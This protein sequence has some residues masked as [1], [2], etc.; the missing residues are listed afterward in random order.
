MRAF[1]PA[2]Y[3]KVLEVGCGA[4]AFWQ[5]LGLASQVWGIEPVAAAAQAAAKRVARVLQ[6]TYE[7]VADQIPESYFDL[8]VCNDVIEHMV[9]H[10]RFLCSVH[11]KLRP[12]GYLVGSVPNLR[13]YRVLYELL[14]RRDW[15]YTDVGIMDRTHLRFYTE[16]SLR[17][18]LT[19]HGFEVEVL[20][21]IK[22]TIQGTLDPL[23]IAKR[24]FF[25]A[26]SIATFGGYA[27]I[28]Y[29]QLA[30]RAQRSN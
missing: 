30:F 8:I 22:S 12:G 5:S 21:G 17:R 29:L 28:K 27:D 10:E 18:T 25:G 15:Q 7:D 4:G 24:V 11:E 26:L 14:V 1:L 19:M 3:D 16:K 6:G 9:D 20:V 23:D 13:N 2:S